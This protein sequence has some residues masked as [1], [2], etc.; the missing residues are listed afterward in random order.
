[1]QL[2]NFISAFS[3]FLVS[4]VVEAKKDVK[5]IVEVRALILS[6]NIVKHYCSVQFSE[7]VLNTSMIFI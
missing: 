3:L 7:F 6:S 4:A 2:L 5:V 1:M